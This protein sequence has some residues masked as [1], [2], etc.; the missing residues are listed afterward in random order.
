MAELDQTRPSGLL[1]V[2]KP[3][4]PSSA[5]VVHRLRRQLGIRAIGH[6]GTLDPLASG[7]LVL[8]VGKAT[9]LFPNFS[10]LDKVYEGDLCLGISTD[11]DDREGTILDRRPTDAIDL[12]TIAR[13]VPRFLG[14]QM[15]VP[16]QFSA[17]KINGRPAYR[18]ARRGVFTDLRPVEVEIR[19]LEISRWEN[20]ILSLL[21]DCSKG[22]YIR[23]LARDFGGAL[24]CGAH[25]WNL[26]RLS[27]GP[28]QVSDAWPLDHLLEEPTGAIRK[29]L[30][31]F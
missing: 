6:A 8:L 12:S 4:G 27:V 26:R 15:Q 11:T 25:L 9:K 28:F 1:L 23:S 22:T 24:G 20:P 13:M 5:Q 18:N 17:K 10:A 14:R 3:V 31:D 21:V 7:L 29:K 30:Q 16:P 19:R 2:D